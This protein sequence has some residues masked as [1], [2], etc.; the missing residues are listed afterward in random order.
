MSLQM[1]ELVFCEGHMSKV[2]MRSA[3][4]QESQTCRL[5]CSLCWRGSRWRCLGRSVIT[6]ARR[7]H[8]GH[9]ADGRDDVG[10]LGG[11]LC[12]T[13]GVSMAGNLRK[14]RRVAVGKAKT[15]AYSTTSAKCYLK[16][17]LSSTLLASKHQ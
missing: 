15:D 17:R 3:I 9:L 16:Y 8:R 2:E 11:G 10:R 1:V 7:W 4:E 13:V 6:G 12:N 14:L 5:S